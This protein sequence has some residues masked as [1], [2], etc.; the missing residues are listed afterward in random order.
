MITAPAV[1]VYWWGKVLVVA[2]LALLLVF[3]Y[4]LALAIWQAR[5]QKCRGCCYLAFFGLAADGWIHWWCL[6][7]G[8]ELE[9]LAGCPLRREPA[10][11]VRVI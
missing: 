4:V 6:L 10:V 7:K 1:S 3:L 9:D 8:E 5:H 2:G 11:P